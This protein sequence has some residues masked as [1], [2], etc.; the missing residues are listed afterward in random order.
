MVGRCGFSTTAGLGSDCLRDR[1]RKCVIVCPC[2][3]G[4]DGGNGDENGGGGG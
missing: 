4:N 1:T 3:F 2:G